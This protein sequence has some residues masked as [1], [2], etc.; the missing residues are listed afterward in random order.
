[1]QGNEFLDAIGKS[2]R[3]DTNIEGDFDCFTCRERVDVGYYD[4]ANSVLYWWCSQ[5]HES[6]IK[7]IS[8]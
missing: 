7:E 5:D 3:P 6:S 1:M 8:L 4:Y 2:S